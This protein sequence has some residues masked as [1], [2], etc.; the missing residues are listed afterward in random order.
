MQYLYGTN[1]LVY[2]QLDKAEVFADCLERECRESAYPDEDDEEKIRIRVRR[3]RR[4][5]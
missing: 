5:E 2:T 1:R 3:I 4:E